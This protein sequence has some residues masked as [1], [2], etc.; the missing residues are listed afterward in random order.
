MSMPADARTD[1][2]VARLA[3][4]PRIHN[5]VGSNSWPFVDEYEDFDYTDEELILKD[6]IQKFMQPPVSDWGDDGMDRSAYHDIIKVETIAKGI[7]PFPSMYKNREG[8]LGRSAKSISNTHAP[9][10]YVDNQK[11]GHNYN[12]EPLPDDEDPA[13]TLEDIALKQLKEC[14]RLML[15]EYYEQV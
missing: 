5:W 3:K 9:G 10:F 11:S 4:N 14:I 12:R 8:H 7:S 15:L 6:K 1:L 13:Y 2:G